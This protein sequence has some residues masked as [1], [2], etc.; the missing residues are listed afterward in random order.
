[1]KK[2]NKKKLTKIDVQVYLGIATY[3]QGGAQF[4]TG[5]VSGY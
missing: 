2:K 5:G 3:S 1:M 4:P